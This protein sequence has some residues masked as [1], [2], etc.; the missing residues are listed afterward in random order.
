MRDIKG[1]VDFLLGETKGCKRDARCHFC[2]S[3]V[4]GFKRE[5]PFLYCPPDNRMGGAEGEAVGTDKG[6]GQLSCSREP[7]P[8]LFFHAG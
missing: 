8:G 1:F 7:F 3:S 5:T 6:I 4:Q 2:C